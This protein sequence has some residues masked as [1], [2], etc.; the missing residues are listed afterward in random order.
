MDFT[1]LKT[2]VKAYSGEQNDTKCGYAVN[3][4]YRMI[5]N[6]LKWPQLKITC[7][8][9]ITLVAGT[10]AYALASNFR[11]I[12]SVYVRDSSGQPI[13]LKGS[14]Q[15]LNNVNRGVAQ[16]YKIMKAA[17]GTGATREAF[18]VYLEQIPNADF[19]STYT[20]LYYDYY[21]Q[22]TDLSGATDVLQ[23]DLGDEQVIVWGAVTLLTAK[24][25]DQGGFGMFAQL[26]QD[27]LSDMIQKAIDLYG[28]GVIVGPGIEITE[29]ESSIF[30]DY[31]RRL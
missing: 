14:K 10:Q 9:P 16:F 19:V 18:K 7:A 23:I 24:Q 27:A 1:A 2:A 3:D 25:T 17:A 4:M 29:T 6:K 12:D 28:E 11:W 22:P 15:V 20:S 26:Y 30:T 8:T 21:Y 13:F 5:V 31:G